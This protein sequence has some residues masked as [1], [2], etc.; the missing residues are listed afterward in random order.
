VKRPLLPQSRASRAVAA[1]VTATALTVTTAGCEVFSPTQTD[2]P[3]VPADGVQSD[4]G[5]VAVRDLV[6]VLTDTGG[7]MVS[8]GLVNAGKQSVTVQFAPQQQSGTGSGSEIRLGPG[9]GVNLAEKGLQLSGVTAKPGT[10]VPV[11]VTT[12]AAGTTLLNVPAV[13]AAGYYATVTPG[14][15]T[16]Q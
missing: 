11:S 15:V 6:L 2:I 7:A 10:L 8:G 16:T 14:P 1:L 4:V 12:S 5:Q 3:Y 13:Q 9:Q